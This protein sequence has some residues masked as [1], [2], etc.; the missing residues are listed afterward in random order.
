MLRL[1]QR[2]SAR[3]LEGFS[4]PREE[5]PKSRGRKI[6]TVGRKIQEIFFRKSRLSKGLNPDQRN[7]VLD[8]RPTTNRSSPSVPPRPPRR[9]FLIRSEEAR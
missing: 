1:G 8:A 6:Q 4:K 3:A 7:V 2:L 5:K 9:Q